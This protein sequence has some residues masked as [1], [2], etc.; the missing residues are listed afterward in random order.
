MKIMFASAHP[1]IPQIAGGAQSSVHELVQVLQALGHD[2]SVLSGLTHKGWVGFRAR[3]SLKLGGKRTVTDTSLGYAVHRGWH[4]VEGVEEIIAQEAPDVVVLQ[5][6]KPVPIAQKLVELGVPVV[7]YLRNVEFEDLGGD[8]SKLRRVAAIANSAF[9]AETFSRHY[10]LD[11]DVIL[12]I[13][14]AESYRTESSRENVTF[15]NPHP[16]KGVDVALD[17]AE[18]C[19]DIPFVFVEGWT[20]EP[21]DSE[22]LQARLAALPNVTLRP[23]TRDMNDVYSSA[24]IVLAPSQ[25]D[26]AFGRIAAEAHVSGIPVIASDCGGLPEAVGPGGVLVARDAPV[27]DWVA[28]LRRLWDDQEHYEELSQA[29]REFSERPELNPSSQVQQ[30]MAILE[31]AVAENEAKPEVSRVA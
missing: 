29:A 16:L 3:V 14:K 4:P 28:A 21:E 25:W 8:P 2:V 31:R 10:G 20:L 22:R 11:S 9:T 6:G 18:Q 13:I 15:I 12:P 19:P 5:S 27:A 26:E 7:L 24:R 30:L 17:V 23:R 1:Y